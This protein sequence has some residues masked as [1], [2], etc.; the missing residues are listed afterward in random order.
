MADSPLCFVAMPNGQTDA[1]QLAYRAWYLVVLQKAVEEAG[2]RPWLATSSPAPVPVTDEFLKHLVEAPMALFDLGGFALTGEI[3]N[4]NVMYELGIRHAFGKPAIVYSPSPRL[5]F[6]VGH[7][8]AVVA[9]RSPDTAEG[10]AH[11]I[12][13][14]IRAAAKGAFWKPLDAVGRVAQL[15][16]LAAHDKTLRPIIELISSLSTK[17]D[18][19]QAE[20][21]PRFQPSL[22]NL[23]YGQIAIPEQPAIGLG[24]LGRSIAA[25]DFAKMVEE[26]FG[27]L[28]YLNKAKEYAYRPAVKPPEKLADKPADKPH[29]PPTKPSGE[30]R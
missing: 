3:P 4:P 15:E 11:D 17:V 14:Q 9:A 20:L 25:V 8:R 29:K 30:G 26:P 24:A 23:N 10:V 19:L 22:A 21:K 27:T 12:A 7:G 1:E 16:Q 13:E 2:F 28:E 6:D 5:P 18:S